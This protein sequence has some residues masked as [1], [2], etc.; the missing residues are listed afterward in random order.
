MKY[1]TV[2]ILIFST[3]LFHTKTQAVAIPID[4]VG[5]ALPGVEFTANNETIDG[6]TLTMTGERPSTDRVTTFTGAGVNWIYNFTV[7]WDPAPG[8]PDFFNDVIAITGSATHIKPIPGHGDAAMGN[9]FSF[10]TG[11][12]LVINA[13]TPATSVATDVGN[14]VHDPHND[15]FSATLSGVPFNVPLTNIDGFDPWKFVLTGS[16]VPI[17]AAFWLFFSSLV[18]LL[19][20]SRW[21]NP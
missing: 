7:A 21:K 11:G 16:H 20:I 14:T 3:L 15:L 8:A 10:G 5:D 13:D 4:I 18:G 6:F 1:S 2:V 9:V 19:G 17:P 12:S